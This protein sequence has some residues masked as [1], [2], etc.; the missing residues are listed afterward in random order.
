MSMCQ[1][2]VQEGSRQPTGGLG[3]ALM[4]QQI[5][6][7]GRMLMQNRMESIGEITHPVI[8]HSNSIY[9]NCGTPRYHAAECPVLI[10]C[11]NCGGLGHKAIK[12]MGDLPLYCQHCGKPGHDVNICWVANLSLRPSRERRGRERRK[13]K[14]REEREGKRRSTYEKRVATTLA[15]YS[16]LTL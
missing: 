13:R 9:Y 16:T 4:Q 7:M 10:I 8:F 6:S 14:E 15:H 5:G 12:C 11:K 2:I 1:R 3:M